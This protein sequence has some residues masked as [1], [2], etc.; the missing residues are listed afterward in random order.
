VTSGPKSPT[1]RCVAKLACPRRHGCASL[2]MQ[3]FLTRERPDINPNTT[4]TVVSVD[5]GT[6]PQGGG[7]ETGYAGDCAVH[8]ACKADVLS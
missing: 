5:N 4:Y 8:R 1:S 2:I 3:A 7:K 6:D